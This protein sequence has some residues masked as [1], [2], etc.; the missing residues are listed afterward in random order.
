MLRFL[1]T[2]G[3]EGAVSH[4]HEGGARAESG[5]SFAVEEWFGFFLGGGKARGR[6]IRGVLDARRE[7]GAVRA[8]GRRGGRQKSRHARE[9]TKKSSRRAE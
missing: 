5:A 7:A 1:E 4:P 2:H 8:R 3:V 6:G 9:Q